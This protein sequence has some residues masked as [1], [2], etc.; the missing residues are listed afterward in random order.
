MVLSFGW[1]A[2]APAARAVEPPPDGGYANQTTA[3]G[4]D[5]L[6]SLTSGIDNTALGFDALH[7]VTMG[8]DNTATGA[9]T[10][11][12]DTGIIQLTQYSNRL[13]LTD[14]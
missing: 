9:W 13:K 6:A 10:L 1:F 12:F 4:T 8:N 5:A 2:L 3:E 11:F 14:A 7:V